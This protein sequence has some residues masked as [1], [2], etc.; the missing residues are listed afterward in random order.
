MREAV[1]PTGFL[2]GRFSTL[3]T[4]AALRVETAVATPLTF[5]EL[6]EK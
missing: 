4:V 6:L 1:W 3:H 5:K 2:E